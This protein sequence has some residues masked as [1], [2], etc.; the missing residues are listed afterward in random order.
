[1]LARYS[2]RS[3]ITIVVCFLLIAMSTMG[4]LAMKQ[5][6]D[7]NASTVEIADS[8]L[9]SVRVLGEIRAATITYRAIVR[10]HLLATNESGK[11]AQEVLL[12][13][14]IEN[15]EK[16]QKRYEP[17][18]NSDEERAFYAE[19]KAAWNE[20]LDGVN[21]VLILS[22]KNADN[23]ARA[24]HAKAS[25]A[26]VKSDEILQKD[27]D[28]NNKGADRA[29]TNAAESYAAAM[30]M[31]LMSLVLA[32]II[33]IGAAV[34]LVRDVSTGIK[35]I[36]TPMQ[37]LGAGDLTAMVPHQGERT[38]IGDMAN[39]LQVFKEALIAKKAADE[40]AAIDAEEKIRRGERVN[41]ITRDFE[42]LIGDIVATV[43][44]A[45][46][47]LEASAGTLTS[48]AERSQKLTAVVA[49][50]SAEA[51]TN[52][53]SVASATEEMSSSVD[54]ISRQVQESAQHRKPGGR[55]GTQDQQP[56]RRVGESRGADRRRR[57]TDQHHCRS[58]QPAGA[59]RHHRSGARGRC[60]PRFC[61]RRFRSEGAGRADG[62]SH[63]R[64]QSA[65]I[66]HPGGNPGIGRCHQGHRRHH[67]P[68]V[69]DFLEHCLGGGTAG[70]GD[71]GNLAQC[72]AGGRGHHAGV[73]KHHR[74]AAR[75]LRDRICVHPGAVGR[76]VA[77]LRKQ[78]AEG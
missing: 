64:D 52:V 10:S 42:A 20:Y 45:S 69:G 60:R 71:Q 24:L 72:A 65:D 68:D 58:D 2:I 5:M 3:K 40:A 28:L 51:S 4:G 9:P 12:K 63:R 7:I 55:R 53:Q 15:V 33:G 56:R 70:R 44:S 8:W 23:E 78:P 25:L 74:R 49:S 13:K 21:Q 46:T 6:S 38:E 48:A 16:A 26:G 11:Q 43:S 22:R 14:W 30:K 1:M 61:R 39:S 35:S 29:A 41:A 57:R 32:M 76:A 54:E 27:V 37:A 17:L 75:R 18:I 34:L 19:S 67:R 73:V 62:K 59:E 47:E 36:V 66:Q 77:V 31:V 50:A